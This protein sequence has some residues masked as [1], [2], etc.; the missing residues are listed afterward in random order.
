MAKTLEGKKIGFVLAFRD[1]KDQE[2]FIPKQILE[3]AGAEII[4]ISDKKGKAIGSE[5]GEADIQ[6]T[7]KELKEKGLL[8]FDAVFFV[9]GQGAV[10]HLDNNNSYS[11]VREAASKGIVFGAICISPTILAKAGVLQGKKATVWS[12]NT[13]RGP[14]DTLQENGAIFED[15][16]VAP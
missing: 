1:F 2:Y 10:S 4:N 6:F 12:S 11:I 9:G 3:N 15:K 14:I 16:S 7:L 8:G 5:G 13:A